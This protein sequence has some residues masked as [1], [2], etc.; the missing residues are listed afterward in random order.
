M[1]GV[2]IFF[3][4]FVVLTFHIITVLSTMSQKK[5]EVF[6]LVLVFV[7]CFLFAAIINKSSIPLMTPFIISVIMWLYIY[8][9]FI[10]LNLEKK[11]DN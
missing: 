4:I 6:F 2:V 8:I 1:N 11:E 10:G 9:V 5:H 3:P 7:E